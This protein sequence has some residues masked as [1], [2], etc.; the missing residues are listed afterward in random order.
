MA[1]GGRRALLEALQDALQ[2]ITTANGFNNDIGATSVVVSYKSPTD[3][4]PKSRP[5]LA[6]GAL[7]SA[8][9]DQQAT[10][11]KITELTI[12]IWVYYQKGKSIKDA[13][14]HTQFESMENL[15]TDVYKAIEERPRLSGQVIWAHV[16]SDTVSVSREV[17]QQ[18]GVA[19]VSLVC[20]YES[21]RSVA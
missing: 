20:R 15:I 19:Q 1:Y 8:A 4:N 10:S 6:M 17:L 3:I 9:H 7:I 21:L 11:R 2:R 14:G 12:P 5:Y 18:I 16:Q 13:D